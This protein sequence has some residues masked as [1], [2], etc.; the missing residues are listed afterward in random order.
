MAVCFFQQTIFQMATG[1]E[2]MAKKLWFLAGAVFMG[3]AAW[4]HI[5]AFFMMGCWCFY[6]SS[7]GCSKAQK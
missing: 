7:D 4:K 5:G 1:L 2:R 6:W 3:L